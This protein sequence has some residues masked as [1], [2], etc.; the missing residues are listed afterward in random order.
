MVIIL[1]ISVSWLVVEI[2]DLNFLRS[3]NMSSCSAPDQVH[4]NIFLPTEQQQQLPILPTVHTDNVVAASAIMEVFH[5]TTMKNGGWLHIHH[6]E[7][8][9]IQKL[10]DVGQVIMSRN[11]SCGQPNVFGE[12]ISSGLEYCFWDDDFVSR[13][14]LDDFAFERHLVD[15]VYRTLRDLD[16]T[17]HH[18]SFNSSKCQ[19]GFLDVGVNVAD[20]AS[21]LIAALP[22]VPFF[23]IEGTPSTGAIAAANMRTSL[24][25]RFRSGNPGAPAVL[26]PFSLISKSMVSTVQASGGLCYGSD[27]SNVG[28]QGVETVDA[29][30][31]SPS[32]V[33]GGT[34]LSHALASIAPVQTCSGKQD[35]PR[36]YIAKFDIQRFEFKAMTS[37]LDWLSDRP[38]C[39]IMIETY[40]E[41]RTSAII[42][43]LLDFGYDSVWRT[44]N[45]YPKDE[46]SKHKEFPPG[47]PYWSRSRNSSISLHDAA[48]IDLDTISVFWGNKDYLFGFEDE[49]K[50]LRR[51]IE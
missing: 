3:M 17:L 15:W 37:A 21:P 35:W 7:Y 10:R 42:E 41:H 19:L 38:P 48:D 26:L 22:E 4:Q 12:A 50:C 47:P 13:Q 14:S 1:A 23:G 9:D 16:K 46:A 11:V 30:H 18:Y 39:Y 51:L 25:H 8:D 5:H 32:L 33:A 49:E 29:V 6:M 2:W 40:K 45:A 34:L 27:P 43:L 20:W 36:I 28:G 44:H 24:E 31:C